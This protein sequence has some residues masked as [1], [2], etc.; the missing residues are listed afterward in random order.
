[1]NLLSSWYTKGVIAIALV[2]CLILAHSLYKSSIEEEVE[3]RLMLQYTEALVKAGEEAA[4]ETERLQNLVSIANKE[5]EE[6]AKNLQRITADSSA[7][8]SRLRK[9]ITTYEGDISSDPAC[10]FSAYTKTLGAV[11]GECA[12]ALT[13]MGAAAQGHADDALMLQQAWPEKGSVCQ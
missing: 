6:N 4:K 3:T 10:S 5:R 13:Q 1:M 8:I 12:E 7:T 9:Q 2:A 11:F